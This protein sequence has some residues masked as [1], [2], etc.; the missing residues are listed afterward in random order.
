[1]KTAY[2]TAEAMFITP[3]WI[4]VTMPLSALSLTMRF[5]QIEEAALLLLVAAGSEVSLQIFLSALGEG[6]A[7]RRR[8]IVRLFAQS[9][10]EETRRGVLAFLLARLRFIDPR[11]LLTCRSGL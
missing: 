4:F 11:R 1:M 8:R 3:A 6:P 2:G 5:E 7:Q 10:V 9:K